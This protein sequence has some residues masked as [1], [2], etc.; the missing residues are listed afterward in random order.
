MSFKWSLLVLTGALLLPNGSARAEPGPW[1]LEAAAAVTR[2]VELLEPRVPT[3]RPWAVRELKQAL[4]LDTRATNWRGFRVVGYDGDVAID[5]Y[6]GRIDVNVRVDLA[7]EDPAQSEFYFLAFLPV[8]A[9]ETTDGEEVPFAIV[10]EQGYDLTV[11]GRPA[12]AVD[13]APTS[14]VFTL[15]GVPE[16]AMDGPISVMLCGWGAV[17]YM[18][19]DVFLP[20]SLGRDFSTMHLNVVL[21]AGTV[22]A[23][24]GVTVA[25]APTGDDREVHTIVQDFPTDSHSFVMGTYEEARIPFGDEGQWIRTLTRPDPSLRREIPILL[26][27][28]RDIL[29]FYSDRYGPFLFPKME[30]GQIDNN[31]GAAFGWPAL[32]WIPDGMLGNAGR[33][34]DEVERRALL[35]HELGHQWFPDIMMNNDGWAAWLSEG[36]AEYSSISYMAAVEGAQWAQSYYDHYAML[37]TYYI[38]WTRDYGLTSM[39]SQYVSS[40]W[41][42]QVVTYFKG[43]HVVHTLE[44]IMG[45]EAFLG[46]IRDLYDEVA[47]RDA[48]Y[49][50]DGL[51]RILEARHGESLDWFFTQWIYNKGYPIYTVGVLPDPEA[52]TVEVRVSRD[53][54]YQFNSFRMPV[55]F[56]VVGDRGETRETVWVEEDEQTFTFDVQGRFVRVKFDPDRVFIKRVGPQLPGDQ[57]LSGEVDAIDLLYTAW[58]QGGALGYNYNFLP[59]ADLDFSGTVDGDDLAIVLD[60][61]GRTLD[62]E[63]GNDAQ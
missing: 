53:S 41:V 26:D 42:Y 59:R 37:Y 33:G 1:S 9:V 17:N 3:E 18:A 51:R 25:I 47:G 57:D 13:G 52:G 7:L 40:S 34:Y 45:T 48:Y 31:A 11:V 50:T 58:G 55:T 63:G 36:F 24:T 62:D 49:N 38:P 39:E 60:G 5:L 6:T 21:P 2:R 14:L 32:L 4:H 27:D 30:V 43:A 54:N 44:Q 28:V 29:D 35:A 20:A 16:C 46:A 8:T 56:G 19:G 61:F 23:S 22:M 15:S 12:S 10:E